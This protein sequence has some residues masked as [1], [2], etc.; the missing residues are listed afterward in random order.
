MKYIGF[1]N[2]KNLSENV[3]PWETTQFTKTPQ[4]ELTVE[5]EDY[6]EHMAFCQKLKELQ[7][8]SEVKEYFG[9]HTCLLC[10]TAV[11]NKEYYFDDI[12]WPEGYLH[13]L[14]DH[15]LVIDSDMKDKLD[16]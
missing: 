5:P 3:M 9:S 10:R 8:K 14:T 11:G 4:T 2:T 1:W 13:Y 15:K 12:V 6:H 16:F 7:D